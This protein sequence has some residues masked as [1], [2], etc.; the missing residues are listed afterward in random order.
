MLLAVALAV[1]VP[2]AAAPEPEPE[3]ERAPEGRK[4]LAKRALNSSD[5]KSPMLF[6][7]SLYVVSLRA[8]WATMVSKL[9]F[10]TDTRSSNCTKGGRVSGRRRSEAQETRYSAV[11]TQQHYQL[12]TVNSPKSC[13][14]SAEKAGAHCWDA[15]SA[16]TRCRRLPGS[17]A[18]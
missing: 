2:V 16:Q 17:R 4:P 13:I 5:D 6:M 3:R 1:A 7:A 14:A 15:R 9:A 10:H 8:L 11:C 18:G 12:G